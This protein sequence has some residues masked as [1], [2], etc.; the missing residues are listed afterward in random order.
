VKGFDEAGDLDLEVREDKK[1]YYASTIVSVD[2][3]I[4]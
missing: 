3:S 2:L 4:R 1:N